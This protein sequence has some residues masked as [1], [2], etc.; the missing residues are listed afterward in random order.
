M[1]KGSIFYP[2]TDIYKTNS[3]GGEHF[4]EGIS[5]IPQPFVDLFEL[6]ACSTSINNPYCRAVHIILPLMRRK[7]ER[8]KLLSWFGFIAHITPGFKMLLQQRDARALLLMAYWFAK[9]QRSMWFLER[10]AV[11][12]GRSIC[13]FL[14]RYHADDSR[15]QALLQVPRSLLWSQE[16]SGSGMESAPGGNWCTL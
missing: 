4:G 7:F 16:Q 6:D 8:E 12:E 2:M 1:R 11:I 9:V 3:F 10:R 5:N 13:L 14:E 15:I